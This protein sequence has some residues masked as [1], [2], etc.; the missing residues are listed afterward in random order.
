MANS[1]SNR[2]SYANFS[3]KMGV[4][5][6]Y[7]PKEELKEKVCLGTILDSSN[8]T[9]YIEDFLNTMEDL[10]P[11]TKARVQPREKGEGSTIIQDAYD[12]IK[13]MMKNDVSMVEYGSEKVQ[14]LVNKYVINVYYIKKTGEEND[15]KVRVPMFGTVQPIDYN[16]VTDL[17][18]RANL[19][20]DVLRESIYSIINDASIANNKKSIDELVKVLTPTIIE[21]HPQLTAGI[22]DKLS[23][24]VA[25]TA[26]ELDQER[27]I[28]KLIDIGY[29]KQ[30][31]SVAYHLFTDK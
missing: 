30:C 28:S 12:E 22:V 8:G 18:K 13:R 10:S 21:R 2:L 3:R 5:A 25:G 4:E 6:G 29:C 24:S 11:E 23:A 15:K 26:T 20:S 16:F 1:P 14:D 31:A 9:R 7:I 27:I 17:E 19:R